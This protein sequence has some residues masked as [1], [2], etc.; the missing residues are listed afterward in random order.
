MGRC[1]GRVSRNRWT[2]YLGAIRQ[3]TLLKD[4]LLATVRA[5]TLPAPASFILVQDASSIHNCRLVQEWFREHSE[6]ELLDWPPK[7]CDLN[8]IENKWAIMC[9]EWKVDSMT[10]RHFVQKAQ[11]LWE[12]I[13]HRPNICINLVDSMP[14]RLREVNNAQ[15]GWTSY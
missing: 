8:P 6:M 12:G 5:L 14:K 7:I 3:Y 13:R 1:A 15:D 2:I 10:R 11:G 9:H 4:V